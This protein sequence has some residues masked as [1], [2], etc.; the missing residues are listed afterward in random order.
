[1]RS[2]VTGGAGFIGSHVV[3]ALLDRGDEVLV[4][5][6]LSSGRREN[7][8][9]ALDRGARL[10]EA[11]VADAAAVADL[12]AG[13]APQRA[14]HLAAQ[15]DVRRSVEEPA[16]D[17]EVN[18]VGTVNLLAALGALAAPAGVVFASTGG[19]IYGEGEGLEL[20]LGEEADARPEAPY[21]MAKLAA[22]GYL[23]LYRRT[24]GAGAASLRFANVYGPRQ[25]PH[26][27]A[28]VV[29]I[30]CGRIR[31][32]VPLTV[33]GDGLQTRDYVYVG[34]VVAAVL[35]AGDRLGEGWRPE[36]PLNVGTGRETTVLEL[37]EQL[38]RCAGSAPGVEHAPDRGGEVRRIA[39][40]PALAGRELGWQPEV[41]LGDGLARTYE[42]LAAAS[43]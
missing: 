5:D 26:G 1:L 4:L 28:G 19:A 23:D 35:A 34:D 43:A 42:A 2:L 36:R 31:E 41:D 40:D 9:G 13:F 21:G 27:E 10:A 8:A 3:D 12:V 30:F 24:A 16:F 37:I 18:V 29:A 33:F 15:I 17:A 6:D 38:T 25:D 20:P 7:L 14:F 32:R 22:E 39:I 11:S